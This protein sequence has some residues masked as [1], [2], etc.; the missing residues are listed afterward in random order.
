M[1]AEG[2]ADWGILFTQDEYSGEDKKPQ[3]SGNRF[4]SQGVQ[5]QHC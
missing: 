3:I 1:S 4:R 2:G 5:D